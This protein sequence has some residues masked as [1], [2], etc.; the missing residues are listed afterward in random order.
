MLDFFQLNKTIFLTILILFIV[1]DL[2]LQNQ[3]V[4]KPSFQKSYHKMHYHRDHR[5]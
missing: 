3:Q 4:I 1:K 5:K 2:M